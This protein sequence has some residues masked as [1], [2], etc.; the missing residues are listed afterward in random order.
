MENQTTVDLLQHEFGWLAE[1]YV[2]IAGVDEVGRGAFAGPVSAGAVV[3]P[4]D[5]ESLVEDLAGVRDSKA[6]TALQRQRLEPVIQEVAI[7]WAVADASAT[8]IDQYGI[9]S[10]ARI[11]MM[12][13]IEGLRPQ[14][15]GWPE[16]LLIDGHYM[17]LPLLGMIPQK[18]MK[19][20]D[21]RSLS[22]SAAS[23]LA[24]VHRD[25]LMVELAEQYPDYGFE[26]NKG[27]GTKHHRNQLNALGPCSAH[28]RCFAP[29]ASLL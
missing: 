22:I 13:A 28:R 18:A 4:L 8:E 21:Q 5:R 16:A 29:I 15:A 7:A 26:F 10:A 24:K 12:R 20:G 9:V 17:A 11:A 19:K 2:L 6:C 25:R 3:L 1:G 27:Y 14:L 23:I